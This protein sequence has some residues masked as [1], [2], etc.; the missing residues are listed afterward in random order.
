VNKEFILAVDGGA[1]NCRALLCT[2][3]GVVLGSAQSGSC[4]YQNVGL[5]VAVA[6]L[7]EVV[8]TVVSGQT[9]QLKAAVFG[10][11]GLDTQED[12]RIVS[13]AINTMLSQLAIDCTNIIIDN[14]GIITLLGAVGQDNGVLV[15]AGTGAI[16]CGITKQGDQARAGGWGHLLDD[17]GSGYAI[18]KSALSHIMR[19]YDGRDRDSGIVKA[20]LDQLMLAE[21]ENII[22]WVYGAN[23][24]I[25]R[26]AALA[27]IICAL[28]EQGDWRARAI[29]ADSTQGLRQIALAVIHRLQLHHTS[30]RLLLSGGLLQN[31]QIFRDQLVDLIRA[32]CP[33]VKLIDPQYPPICG[34]VLRALQTENIDRRQIL[35]RLNKQLTDMQS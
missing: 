7:R 27:P 19:V 20:V 17:S 32:E 30:F 33:Q 12:Y 11:A 1:T 29:L 10:L 22:N 35:D 15:I 9:Q 18:G 16:A 21:P 34:A 13:A 31:T 23:Y 26:V 4:N 3:D 8:I 5:T 6:R 28:A 14:D 2:S 25:D 24:S